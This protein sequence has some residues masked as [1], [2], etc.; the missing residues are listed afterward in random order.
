MSDPLPQAMVLTAIVITLGM[1]AFLLALAY[2]SWQ[3]H[4]HDE[5]QDDAEDRR[6]AAAAPRRRRATATTWTPGPTGATRPSRGDADEATRRTAVPARPATAADRRGPWT[7]QASSRCRCVLPLFAARR[8]RWRCAAPAPQRIVTV[9][10]SAWCSP[11]RRA[12]V[13]LR[14]DAA[15]RRRRR[16]GGTGRDRPR[17]LD[18]LARL[19][20]V[21][22]ARRAH[23][24]ASCS[25]RSAPGLAVGQDEATGRRAPVPIYHPT[26][27]VLAAGVADAFLSGDLF[28]LYVGFEI[29]LV[30]SYVLL[31]LGGTGE[32]IRAGIIYVVVACCPRCCSCGVALIYAATG[33]VNLAQLASGCRDRPRRPAGPA[34]HAAARVRIKAAVFP[35][36]AWL[37]DSYP[38][39]P[40]PVTAVFAGLLTKVGV[41]AIIR[42][43]RCCSP[44]AAST[45]C[46]CGRRWRRWSSASSARSRRTTSSGCCRSRWSATSAT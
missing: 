35:L 5:V 2:R 37:P 11:P 6:I 23:A 12:A 13:R 20:L 29:L 17:W 10:A 32:R 27:L 24:R 42:T 7:V 41:Y 3:L 1:T 15:R 26:F 33:T 8:S 18:R 38:T 21:V 14:R 9:A 46:C 40:A 36:S 16:L 45:T 25:T 44:T 19:M 30:A 43:R 39:A 28:N 4:R 22:I 31:T 34:G